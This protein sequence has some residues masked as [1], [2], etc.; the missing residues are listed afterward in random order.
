MVLEGSRPIAE[1]A[2]ELGLNAGTLGNWVSSYRKANP[3]EEE[4]LTLSERARLRELERE[5]RELKMKN[6]FLGKAASFFAQE[7]R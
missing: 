6:E 7:Y 3:Q 5:N 4:P 1:V 2:R